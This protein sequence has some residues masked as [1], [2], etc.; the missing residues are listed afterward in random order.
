MKYER[1][2]YM[3]ETLELSQREMAKLLNISKSTY[4][5]WETGETIIPLKHLIKM[6]NISNISIDYALGLTNKKASLNEK[7]K[8]DKIAFGNKL[9]QI[10]KNNNLTQYELANILN[11]TQSVISA[12]ENGKNLIQTAFLYDE[13]NKFE[14]T[15]NYIM[16]NLDK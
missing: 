5:R 6:C 11:T 7:I 1:I 13:C 10:R 4:A 15:V 3:R 8:I 14:I 2:I 16:K 12:Y 9:K